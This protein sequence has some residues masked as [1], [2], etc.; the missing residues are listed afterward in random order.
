MEVNM[1]S[2]RGIIASA[3]W[4]LGRRVRR[5]SIVVVFDV[6]AHMHMEI[7]HF[8]RQ[9]VVLCS[10]GVVMGK[11][12][13]AVGCVNRYRKGC[14]LSFYRFPT[15][16]ERRA[17]WVAAVDKKVTILS[18]VIIFLSD[19]CH[20]KSPVKRRVTRDLLKR[21]I[22]HSV[23][24]EAATALLELGNADLSIEETSQ[25]PSP[26]SHATSSTMTEVSGEQIVNLQTECQLLREESYRLREALTGC[27]NEAS[28]KNDDSKVKFYTGLPSFNV[29]MALFTFIF[30][31]IR[32]SRRSM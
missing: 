3:L 30:A 28:L 22:E 14:G 4:K 19:F 16:R 20:L 8:E 25:E 13:C 31:H 12:C 24:E 9:D 7:H 17:R 21:M 5:W 10:R 15:D 26:G 27:L 23:R 29:L 1:T 2:I 11:S 6:V 32:P 18:R